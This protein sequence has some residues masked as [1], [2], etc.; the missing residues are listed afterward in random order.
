MPFIRRIDGHQFWIE[1][2][3]NAY[4]VCEHVLATGVERIVERYEFVGPSY[5]PDAL[6]ARA[7][8]KGFRDT[9]IPVVITTE[10]EAALKDAGIIDNEDG[11]DID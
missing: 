8:A 3:D 10:N 2:V 7:M 1:L 9:I 4:A 6:A 11:A 5:G